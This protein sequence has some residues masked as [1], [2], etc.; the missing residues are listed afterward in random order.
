M[1]LSAVGAVLLLPT[2]AFAHA[3]LLTPAPRNTLAN[4]VGPCGVAR[5]A[6]SV[7]FAPG[8][9]ITVTW[10]ETIDH[11]G[12]YRIAL[13]PANDLGFDAN[14]LKD[15]IPNPTGAQATNS[16]TVTLPTTPCTQCTLQLIQVMTNT[17]PSS[18]YYSCTDITIGTVNTA[19]TVATAASATPATVTGTTAQLAV[20]GADNAGEAALRYTWAATTAPA[21]VSFSANDTNAAK[22]TTA[23]FT[24]AGNYVFRVTLTDAAGLT[25]T[26]NVSVSVTA[27]LGSILV[28]P[29]T[30]TVAMSGTRQFTS[31]AYDQ[32]SVALATQ[33]TPTWTVAGGGSID[34]AGLFSGGTAPGGPFTVTAS[35]GGKVGTAMVTVTAGSAPTVAT[36][37]AAAMPTVTSTSTALSVLGADDG[38]EAA[39]TYTWSAASGPAP[40]LFGANGNNAA[41]STTASFSKAGS[42]S[43][44]VS[45]KDAAN[46]TVTSVVGVV[47]NQTATA[48]M[49]SPTSATVQPSGT[50][51]FAANVSDQFSLSLATQPTI[52]W[53]VSGGGTIAPNGT[54]TAAATPGG[55]FTVTATGAGKSG[56]AT[57]SINAGNPPSVATPAAASAAS[58]N[59]TTVDL[60]A[61]GTDDSGE[62]ALT[63]TW[64]ATAAP[65]AVTFSSN[66]SNAAKATTA[67]FTRAGAYAFEVT[68]RDAANL[69]VTSAV[70][71]TVNQALTTVSVAPPTT[72]VGVGGMQPFT[73]SSSDQFGAVLASQPAFNWTTPNGG[74]TISA[75][76][77]FMA[78][79]TPGGPYLVRAGSGGK[80]GT[81]TVM[82]TAAD[83]PTIAQAASASPAEVVGKTTQLTVLGADDGGEAALIYSWK[84]LVAPAL[85]VFSDVGTNGAKSVVATFAKP[86][87]YQ[88]EVEIKDAIGNT[89]VSGI[90]VNVLQTST[91]ISVTAP[92]AS[93]ALGETLRFT[94]AGKDQFDQALSAEPVYQ[95]TVS[96]GGS[97][98]GAGLFTA[99]AE[100]GGP[101]TVTAQSGALSGTAPVTVTA[102]VVPDLIF[103]RV[104][105]DAPNASAKLTG[106]VQLTATAS[107]NVGVVEVSFWV[108]AALV[109]TSA[110]A[111][112]AVTWDSKLIADGEHVVVAI[113]RDAAGNA[114]RSAA[115]LFKVANGSGGTSHGC[116]ASGGVPLLAAALG[117]VMMLMRRRRSQRSISYS[118]GLHTPPLEP[119]SEQAVRPTTRSIWAMNRTRAPGS[120]RGGSTRS[121]ARPLCA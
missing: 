64:A 62:A 113:A 72:S 46:L 56:T 114:T 1:K 34:A 2:L 118:I 66:G 74:G 93:V 48:V 73:A 109:G 78:A 92:S 30:A 12:H 26:S 100:A 36:P 3:H 31:T 97:I 71:V 53:T 121:M 41:K 58:V 83:A 33:P 65:A 87:L 35:S 80:G 42:Y 4:K 40:V 115:V 90:E 57:V 91:T 70:S 103:P 110:A 112:W 45:I 89:A 106:K 51:V 20:L 50:R 117:A 43:L 77:L 47:V 11:P 105:L 108:D 19:P 94:A 8:A 63:Y 60:S 7:N 6:S 27:A 10:T 76:G 95:W 61:L 52:V 55:P 24:R 67:T 25:V 37:A 84:T 44:S 32:F 39:L 16:T 23:T 119:S 85:V 29:A 104:A 17:T 9:T 107:D 88:F 49:V 54:F 111:P 86:G 75:A 98:S 81:A 69:S 28:A 99:A 79:A 101:F 21:T 120:D 116:A 22:A 102:A 68:I 18:N 38:T 13:S 59:S 96:G 5:T 15:N 82:V 14:V